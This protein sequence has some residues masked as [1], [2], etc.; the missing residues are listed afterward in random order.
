MPATTVDDLATIERH[1]KA[2]ALY[3]AK[4]EECGN[5]NAW[6]LG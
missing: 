2:V 3:R 6:R 5:D 4:A 1:E